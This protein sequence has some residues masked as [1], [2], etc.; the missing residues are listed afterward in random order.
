MNGAAVKH[1]W[2]AC[3]NLSAMLEQLHEIAEVL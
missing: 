2:R 3:T 1:R